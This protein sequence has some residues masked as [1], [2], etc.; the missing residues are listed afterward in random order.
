MS[1]YTIPTVFKAVDNLSGPLQRMSA[2]MEKFE[3]STKGV[4]GN[5]SAIQKE[6]FSFA[7]KAAIITGV[8]SMFMYGVNAIMDYEKALHSLEAV[9]GQSA[10]LFKKQIESIAIDTRKSAIDVA[11]SF[12]IVGSAMSEYLD[13]P[14]ALGQITQAGITL[15]KASRMELDPSL[16][17]L[18]STMNQFGFAADQAAN[19]V[20]RLTAGEIVGNISTEKSSAALQRF[21]ATASANNVSLA[22]SIALVQ[23]LGKKMP[24]EELGRSAR[25]MITFMGAIKGAPKNALEQL[26]KYGINL[27]LVSDKTKSFGERL[28]EMKKIEN[29][30]V[31]MEAFFGKENITAAQAIFQQ[32]DTYDQFA[33]KIG[34]TN[35][36]Q[37]QAAVNSNTMANA[38]TELKNSFV[39]V[40]VSGDKL[41]PML[42]LMKSVFF[43]LAKNMD[44]VLGTVGL[45]AGGFILYQAALL[46]VNATMAITNALIGIQGVSSYIKF[47]AATNQVT[48][49]TAALAFAQNTLNLAWAANPVGVVVV[50]VIA[51]TA[52]MWGLSKAFEKVSASEKVANQ[53]K[54]R[55]IENSMEQRAEATA[56]FTAL[57]TAAQGSKAYNATLEKLEQLQPG[58]IEK[59]D[60]QVKAIDK[61]N[62]AEKD[63][64]GTIMKRAEAEAAAQ[65][66][67][68]KAMAKMRAQQEMMGGGTMF[69]KAAEALGFRP[70]YNQ[71]TDA[72]AELEAA[73]QQQQALNTQAETSGTFNGNIDLTVRDPNNRI[74]TSASSGINIKKPV[75]TPTIGQ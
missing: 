28:R 45:L 43:M 71:F 44:L 10:N 70:R 8:T 32:I 14:K 41:T 74:D 21:G 73:A 59:Y 72:S 39:N 68:E 27:D 65:I 53:L 55:T 58:I 38:I 52:A 29:D 56:L 22:E 69:T 50:G 6:L 3:K 42:E 40:L 20:N 5:L 64:I 49:A 34:L 60:L 2:N 26:A 75:T 48:Y 4:F 13:N 37:K 1:K 19:V 35:E 57:R 23:I 17:A 25:N 31:A 47:F 36:A 46:G 24:E 67:R 18:T 15:S 9:T 51:L 61:I 7:A 33:K 11:K 66:V 16:R 62:S 54:E 30:Q 63:L 12:E